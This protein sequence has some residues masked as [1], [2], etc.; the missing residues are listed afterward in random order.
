MLDV[1]QARSC[2][3]TYVSGSDNPD[4]KLFSQRFLL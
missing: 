1:C 4:S 3:E 2:D